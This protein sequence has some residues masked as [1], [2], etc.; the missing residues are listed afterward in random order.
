MNG[1]TRYKATEADFRLFELQALGV[2]TANKPKP[3]PQTLEPA[4]PLRV[5]AETPEVQLWHVVMDAGGHWR[6]GSRRQRL[7][8]NVTVSGSNSAFADPTAM[9][10]PPTVLES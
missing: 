1:P 4:G 9:I 7:T 8:A 10:N 3:A 5:A 2:D 6:P